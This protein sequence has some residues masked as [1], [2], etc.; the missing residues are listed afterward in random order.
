[1]NGLNQVKGMTQMIQSN[2]PINSI[3]MMTFFG[4]SPISLAFF[5]KRSILFTFSWE[6]FDFVDL[7][8]GNRRSAGLKWALATSW[9]RIG[10]DGCL[11]K[12]GASSR[13]KTFLTAS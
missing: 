5:G 7:F 3:Y 12:S 1:M 9:N 4:K 8:L 10:S 13:R 6:T 11:R 2:Q